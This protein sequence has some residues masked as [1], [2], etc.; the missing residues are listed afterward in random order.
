LKQTEEHMIKKWNYRFPNR[1][2]IHSPYPYE[3]FDAFNENLV[4]EIKY[5]FNWYDK[6]L[7]EFDKYSYNSWYA[8]LKKKRFLYVIYYLDK[9]IVFNI[10]DINKSK[11]N[12]DWEYRKMPKQTEFSNRNN[13]IK[14]VGYLDHNVLKDTKNVYEFECLSLQL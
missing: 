12:Y 9:I 10:T 2:L 4:V 11:Y 1:K 13:I 3:R 14:F 5:R 6:L 8:H 7:I